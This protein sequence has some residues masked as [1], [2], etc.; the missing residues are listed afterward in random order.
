MK[1]LECGI[2]VDTKDFEF[3]QDESAK[4]YAKNMLKR[5]K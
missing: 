5:V 1:I 2:E 4:Q 3:I